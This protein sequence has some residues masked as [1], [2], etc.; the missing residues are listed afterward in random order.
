MNREFLVALQEVEKERQ[1]PKEVII[2]ALESALISA[3]RRNF[4]ATQSVRVHVDRDTGEPKVFARRTVVEAVADPRIEASLEEARSLN[5]TYQTGDIVEYEVTPRDFGRIAA[6]TAKQVVMQRIREAERGAIFQQYAEVE[7]EIVKGKSHRI[8]GKTIL[9]EL[10]KTEGVLGPQEQIPGE[11]YRLNELIEAYVVEVKRSPK[12]PQVILSRTHP[13]LLK[14]LLEREI[15]EIANLVVEV[16]AVAREAGSRSKIAVTTAEPNID[17][18]GACVGP[19]GTR[20][21]EIVNSLHGEKIDVVRWDQ[22]PERF[23]ANALSPAK[24]TAVSADEA[25]RIARVTVPAHQLSLAIGKDGQNV[26]LA[27]KLTGWKIDI[28]PQSEGDGGME[29]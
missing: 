24:V 21:Q 1:I 17:P 7:G 4:G 5:P 29:A 8:E 27:A 22:D 18:V 16:R 9:V 13:G 11:R 2:Q 15:P 19:K 6:Q 28:R 12:G 26:R 3:Y 10:D 23:V 25:G 20:I 14:R